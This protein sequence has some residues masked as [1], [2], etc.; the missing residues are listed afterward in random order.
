MRTGLA[1]A[2]TV[3][4]TLFTA[5]RA[6]AENA[7]MTVDMS[8]AYPDVPMVQRARKVEKIDKDFAD[9]L[10]SKGPLDARIAAFMAFAQRTIGVPAADDYAQLAYGV[11]AAKVNTKAL[12]ADEVLVLATILAMDQ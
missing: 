3:A 12:P 2:F 10:R 6:H 11:P 4:T 7:L 5:P 1:I 8:G 9:F